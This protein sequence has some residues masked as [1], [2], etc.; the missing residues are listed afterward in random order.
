MSRAPRRRVDLCAHRPALVPTCQ[1]DV[2]VPAVHRAVAT[3]CAH[4]ALRLCPLAGRC[5]C[6]HLPAP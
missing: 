3:I 6:P 5:A 1:P 4:I 2:R